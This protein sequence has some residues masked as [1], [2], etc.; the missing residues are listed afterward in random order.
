MGTASARDGWDGGPSQPN[1][2]CLPAF[3]GLILVVH[4]HNVSNF[5]CGNVFQGVLYSITTPTRDVWES[6][7]MNG[8]A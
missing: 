4:M 5:H 1:E 2:C 8:Y 6:Y 3:E 7:N